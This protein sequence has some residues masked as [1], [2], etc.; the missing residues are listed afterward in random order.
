MDRYLTTPHFR[1]DDIPRWINALSALIALILAFQSVSAYV[2]P[3]LAYGAF[4][5]GSVANRQVMATLGGRN[6]VMLAAT[7]YALRT[8]NA[9]LLSVTF[10][11]HFAR[12]AQDMFI[13]PYYAGFLTPEGIGQFLTFLVV[14]TVPELL[15][16]LRLQRIARDAQTAAGA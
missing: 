13:V 10:V 15:A 9:A 6:V 11:M 7:L 12:E 14:F 8:Q 16:L 5:L 3:S 2:A 1:R 4:D